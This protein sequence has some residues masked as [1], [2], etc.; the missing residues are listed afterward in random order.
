M[1]SYLINPE[2]R[3]INEVEY[4]G[5]YHSIYGF[6]GADTFDVV[7]IEKGDGIYVDDEGLLKGPSH[8]FHVR[9]MA[10]PLAGNG[11]V[12]G[13]NDDGESIEPK[14][15]LETLRERV[16]WATPVKVN[17]RVIWIMV[18]VGEPA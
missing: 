16:R 7:G 3:T 13:S 8:F 15:T 11:L 6:I 10:T 14:I 18:P 1:K 17:K 4:D 5:D 9:G 12:L 2:A